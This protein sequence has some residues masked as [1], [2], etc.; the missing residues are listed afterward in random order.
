MSHHQR[1]H[2]MALET[3]LV[4]SGLCRCVFSIHVCVQHKHF[5]TLPNFSNNDMNSHSTPLS[6]CTEMSSSVN[7]NNKKPL[8][9]QKGSPPSSGQDGGN[10]S[11]QP[12]VSTLTKTPWGDMVTRKAAPTSRPGQVDFKLKL[13]PSSKSVPHLESAPPPDG[14]RPSLRPKPPPPPGDKP[15]RGPRPKLPGPKPK[16]PGPKPKL[17]GPKPKLP[18]AKPKLPVKPKS[19]PE[20]SKSL[21]EHSPEVPPSHIKG[22]MVA[23][24]DWVVIDS[25]MNSPRFPRPAREL[26]R[27]TS[28]PFPADTKAQTNGQ[29]NGRGQSPCGN[30]LSNSPRSPHKKP[31]TPPVAPSSPSHLST[32]PP[33]R[34]GGSP[35]APEKRGGS[36]AGITRLADIL[37]QPRASTPTATSSGRNDSR[38]RTLPLLSERTRIDCSS[39]P[40]VFVD[41]FEGQDQCRSRLGA[42]GRVTRERNLKIGGSFEQVYHEQEDL[43][44]VEVQRLSLD[45]SVDSSDDSPRASPAAIASD[46]ATS[47]LVHP[48][49]TKQMS[50]SPPATEE[51]VPATPTKPDISPEELVSSSEHSGAV[52]E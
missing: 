10:G 31:L 6:S 13:R 14:I 11:A 38:A 45:L 51:P 2:N 7:S 20:Q 36:P 44:S 8:V 52:T 23:S 3:K 18:G 37:H 27:Q 25:L 21:E 47:N 17:P 34:R 12:S 15:V 28:F 42:M 41:D 16:L 26:D 35:V 19:P 43:H 48:L 39:S 50:P 22:Q 32:T 4:Y 9:P 40:S 29:V 46:I 1:H 24:D 33:V 49:L 5:V 30:A